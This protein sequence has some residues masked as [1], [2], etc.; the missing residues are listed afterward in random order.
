MI[1]DMDFIGYLEDNLTDS[2][3]RQIEEHLSDCAE[4]RQFLADLE[5]SIHLFTTLYAQYPD[6]LD[7]DVPPG[8]DPDDLFSSDMVPLPPEIENQLTPRQ[9][10]R[11]RLEQALAALMEK[12]TPEEKD[13]LKD[14]MD[15]A[16]RILNAGPSSDPAWALNRNVTMQ[17]PGELPLRHPDN[18]DFLS[19]SLDAYEIAIQ[20]TGKKTRVTV[21]KN[22]QP[23]RQMTVTVQNRSG[24]KMALATD[25][26]GMIAF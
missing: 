16:D 12:K 18:T 24:K 6:W 17:A 7:S 3:K 14:T 23:A 19:L 4:C 22:N 15:L 25:K 1:H 13:L 10:V 26:D 21:L 5:K 11:S 20:K 9:D 8:T 2:E